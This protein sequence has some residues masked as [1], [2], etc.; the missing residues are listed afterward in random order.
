MS[1]RVALV[2][3]VKTKRTSASRA[4]DLYQS[5]L[6]LLMRKYA[7]ENADRVVHPFPRN[8]VS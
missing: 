8:T 3:C 4:E 1:A 2:S 7:E 6:F 5:N